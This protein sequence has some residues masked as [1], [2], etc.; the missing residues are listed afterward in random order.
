M[1]ISQLRYFLEVARQRSFSRAAERLGVTQPALSR[2]IGRLEQELGQTLLERQTRRVQLT[3]AGRLL[4]ERATQMLALH[5]DTLQELSRDVS[6]T[7]RI[8]AIPTI[9]PYVVPKL[10]KR[11]RREF[12]DA[13]L[14]VSE[15]TTD[16]LLK[17]CREGEL[18]AALVA[19]PV[20]AR[21]LEIEPLVDEPLWLVVPASHRLAHG[22]QALSVEQLK[23]EPFILLDEVHC[24]TQSVVA[25][26]RERHVQPLI[27]ET[28]HQLET[29]LSLVALGHGI[30][31]VPQMAREARPYR[32]VV[33]RLMAEPRPSRRIALVWN[34]YRFQS[35]LAE[36]FRQ[37]VHKY[38][39]QSSTD[40]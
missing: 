29:V 15:K 19:L 17:M 14:I 3:E 37:T 22:R 23:G 6:R 2:A 8:G 9:C 34:P 25:F 12:P 13:K 28:A 5:D 31:F 10:L 21:Y 26:C 24:L 16:A 27:V 20:A 32:N 18:Q 30:S 36:A 11:L 38:L 7:L 35:R 1:D 4:C 39:A 40:S 33:F